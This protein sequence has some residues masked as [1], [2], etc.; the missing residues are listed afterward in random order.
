MEN[1]ITYSTITNRG[2]CLALNDIRTLRNKYRTINEE[3]TTA[4]LNK[5]PKTFMINRI[6]SEE[7]GPTV[8]KQY[9][10]QC[11]EW[12]RNEIDGTD[13]RF[14]FLTQTDD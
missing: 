8:I 1:K 4:S 9:L 10:K 3:V 7:F 5:L 12:D 13:G 6:L 14:W 2:F 11:E